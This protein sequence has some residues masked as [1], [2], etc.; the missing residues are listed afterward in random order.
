MCPSLPG[1]AGQ[2]LSLYREHVHPEFEWANFS[3]EEQDRI[4]AGEGGRGGKGGDWE[5]TRGR[6]CGSG[7]GSGEACEGAV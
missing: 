7:E 1:L 4:L 2:V 6:G 5:G 3:L